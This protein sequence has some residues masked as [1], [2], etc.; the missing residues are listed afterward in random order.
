MWFNIINFNDGRYFYLRS[1]MSAQ[2]HLKIP[3][4]EISDNQEISRNLLRRIAIEWNIAACNPR[5]RPHFGPQP[6]NKS[7]RLLELHS[8]NFERWRRGETGRQRYIWDWWDRW[9][10]TCRRAA[11]RMRDAELH[12]D[13]F[14][15]F[16]WV[17]IRSRPPGISTATYRPARCPRL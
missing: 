11:L 13:D 6:I 14:I 9:P 1:I 17:C 8:I 2:I 10:P 16:T 7:R 15:R 4:Y 5:S 3:N 12:A